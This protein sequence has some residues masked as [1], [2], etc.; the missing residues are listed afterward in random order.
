M[1]KIWKRPFFTIFL[2]T[3]PLIAR[4]PGDVSLRGSH[5]SLVYQNEMAN[6]AELTRIRDNEHLK[7]MQELGLLVR[8]PTN[9]YLRI[10]R[11]LPSLRRWCRPWVRDFLLDLAEAY[12]ARFP[13]SKN[14]LQINSAVRTLAGQ[15]T[16]DRRNAN[17]APATGPTASSHTT[18]ATIDI[19]KKNHSAEEVEWLGNYLLEQ[20][21]LNK[22]E[23]TEEFYNVVFHFM[24]FRPA[25]HP[26]SAA[27]AA[28]KPPEKKPVAK[29]KVPLKKNNKRAEVRPFFDPYFS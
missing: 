16:L 8:L 10:D 11:R 22:V 12:H 5:G 28:A 17:A 19:T 1:R 29:N 18:G 6:K 20:E 2:I 4:A 14:Q 13:K 24:V 15:A 7:R 25:N 21:R 26:P 23:V 3:A 9:K 27:E